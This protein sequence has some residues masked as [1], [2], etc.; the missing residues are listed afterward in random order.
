[1]DPRR[2]VLL[3]VV[4]TA[5]LAG[6]ELRQEVVHGGATLDDD[7]SLACSSTGVLPPGSAVTGAA[8][9]VGHG[10]ALHVTDID[11]NRPG[12]EVFM[13]HKGT[14]SLVADVLGVWR[15]EL[16]RGFHLA[17]DTDWSRVPLPSRGKVAP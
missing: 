17:S 4:V 3:P 2:S 1:M 5:V 11:P 10:D 7:G 6:R 9:R 8:V 12:L 13:V 16:V 14:P 15:E